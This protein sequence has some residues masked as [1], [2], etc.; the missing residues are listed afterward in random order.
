MP[1]INSVGSLKE[2]FRPG[3]V[4]IPDQIVDRTRG[5]AN[6]FFGRGIAAHVNFA[7]PFCSV[8][9][10]QLKSAV[11]SADSSVVVHSGGTYVCIEGPAF[12]TRA[13][14]QLYRSW[15]CDIIGMTAIPEAKLAREAGISYATLALVTD[16]D[17]WRTSD[18]D[19]D[20]TDI[21]RILQQNSALA[22][23]VVACV[24]PQLA[25]MQVPDQISQSLS[26]AIL[27]QPDLIPEKTREELAPIVSNA[28]SSM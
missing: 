27:T 25:S 22:C 5:R 11:A 7:D 21:L 17:C 15:G 3:D 1:H 9:G 19:V 18:S 2:E 12:S 28:L 6:T 13:E 16:Y 4:V 10:A 14:S 26:A 20:V 24:A 23:K 8:L